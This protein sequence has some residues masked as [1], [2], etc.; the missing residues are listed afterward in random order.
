[1]FI[2]CGVKDAWAFRLI[3]PAF[4]PFFG[5]GIAWAKALILQPS[6][7]VSVGLLAI[8]PTIS[9]HHAYYSLTLPFTLCYIMNLWTDVLAVPTHFFVNPLLCWPTHL[10]LFWTLLANIPA[11]PTHF[12]I[13]SLGLPWLIYFLFTSFTPNGLFTRSFRLPQP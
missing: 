10:Y 3:F 5:L 4:Y 1:M 8:G 9:L 13:S 7:S 11:V 6:P 2:S 12:I